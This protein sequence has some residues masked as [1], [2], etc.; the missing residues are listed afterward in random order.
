MRRSQQ[1]MILPLTLLI[2]AILLIMS[3]LMIQRSDSQLNRLYV[4]RQIWEAELAFHSAEQRVQFAMLVGEQEPS[5]YRVGDTFIPTDG[6]PLLLSN[7]VTIR[8]QDQAGMLSLFYINKTL[9]L[10]LLNSY[11]VP[12]QANSIANAIIEWQNI[13]AEVPSGRGAPFRSLDELMLIPGITPEIYNGTADEPGLKH[14]LALSGSSWINFGAI[15]PGLM[16]RIFTVGELE[17]ANFV[18]A[19]KRGRWSQVQEMLAQWNLAGQ[20]SDLTPSSRYMIEYE[21]K[22]I[23]AKGDYQIRASAGNPARRRGWFF[24]DVTRTFRLAE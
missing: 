3:S 24:P 19:R 13:D 9:L 16:Q 18:E 8:V 4:D 12:D 21:Y 20:G 6:E 2:L 1:G 17:I 7:Q 5:G 14:W 11:Y 15:S 23:R 10:N 22:G